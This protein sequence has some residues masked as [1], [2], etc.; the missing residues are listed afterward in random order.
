MTLDTH[1]TGKT[2]RLRLTTVWLNS[3]EVSVIV[4]LVAKAKFLT[5]ANSK[6]VSQNKGDTVG[7]TKAAVWLPNQKH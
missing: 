6:E 7:Q 4:I 2:L 3:L 1:E 5:V